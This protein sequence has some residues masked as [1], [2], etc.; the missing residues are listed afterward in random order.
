MDLLSFGFDKSHH[1]RL[2]DDQLGLICP[3]QATLT[4]VCQMALVPIQKKDK[5]RS[6]A[7]T[8][9][10]KRRCLISS[11][12]SREIQ[13]GIDSLLKSS[14]RSLLFSRNTSLFEYPKLGV[15]RST[16]PVERAFKICS[17]ELNNEGKT[18]RDAASNESEEKICAI[19]PRATP[20]LG[21]RYV[22]VV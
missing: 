3:T 17:R 13:K 16:G 5:V 6:A 20:C 21:R 19:G 2:E 9:N 1:V 10:A 7:E 12:L 4:Q 11:S 8:T 14:T 22:P 15:A 18:Q